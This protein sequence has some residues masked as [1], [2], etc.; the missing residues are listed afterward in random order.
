MIFEIAKMY[1]VKSE[2]F[3]DLHVVAGNFAIGMS[4]NFPEFT[5]LYLCYFERCDSQTWTLD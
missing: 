4:E 2:N 1:S 3:T 5:E